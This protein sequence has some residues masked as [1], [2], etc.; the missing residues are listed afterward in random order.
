MDTE[1]AS[2]VKLRSWST[3]K[4][5]KEAQVH[6][7]HTIDFTTRYDDGFWQVRVYVDPENI[8]QIVLG[9]AYSQ[10]AV[11]PPEQV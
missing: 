6:H 5:M 7:S 2:T 4:E 8:Q 1:Y 11:R 9:Y 10:K 3:G